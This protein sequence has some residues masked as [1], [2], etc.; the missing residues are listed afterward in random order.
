MLKF[1]CMISLFWLPLS[2]FS[3]ELEELY[4]DEVPVQGQSA[5]ERSQAIKKA[6]AGVLVKV[7]GDFG[8]ANSSQFSAAYAQAA[9]F[10]LRYRYLVLENELLWEEGY[11]Q[12]LR[13]DFDSNAINQFLRQSGFSTLESSGL[14]AL[15]R[16]TVTGVS[17]VEDYAYLTHYLLSLNEVADVQVEMV[18]PEQVVLKLGVRNGIAELMYAMDSGDMMTPVDT[19]Y[20]TGYGKP[21]DLLEEDAELIYRLI[22]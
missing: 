20:L 11:R 5:K 12:M 22:E 3:A 6:L 7:S 4:S 1:F 15:V 19:H 10:L 16:L 13:V 18:N 17:S 9:D 2:L 21:S 14:A 8:A